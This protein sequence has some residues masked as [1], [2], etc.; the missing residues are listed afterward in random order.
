MISEKCLQNYAQLAIQLGVNV[1]PDQ[2]LVIIAPVDCADF[3]RRCVEEGYKAGAKEVR[4]QWSDERISKISYQYSSLQVLQ[5]IPDW[6]IEREQE[7]VDRGYCVLYLDSSI[8]SLMKDINQDL[9]RQVTMA[10]QTILEPFQNYTMAN[11]GQWSIVAVPN[12]QWAKKVFPQLSE[13]AAM[14]ALWD[15][16]LKTVRVSEE[17][18]ALQK[19]QAHNETLANT[20]RYLNEHHFQSLHFKNALGTN[21]TI[22]LVED[23]IWE[24]GSEKTTKEVLFNPNMPTE[25]A[26]T[27]PH[28]LGVQGKVV[29]TKPLSY[30][31]KLIDH[32]WIE[33]KDGK[34]VAWDAQQHKEA[35]DDLIEFDEG[36]SYLG[37]VALISNDSPI[38][39]SGILFYDTLFDE[40]ASCHLAL[41]RAYP[42]NIKDGLSMSEQQLI[43]KGYNFSKTHVD[44]MF[45]SDDMEIMGIQK[46]GKEVQLFSQGNFCVELK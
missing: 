19:W 20:C 44:F 42:S 21:L 7:Q 18:D 35:L 8:P 22:Q 36:S 5:H 34:A 32:F 28:R 43:E 13:D 10:R 29:A 25:E 12:V 6:F 17:G 24:G 16:I 38:S 31:G 27:M 41:G 45:G 11:Q 40:N 26:F 15:A 37:E 4:V 30:Q 46:D 23:H 2:L 14:Q 1:Q 9:I 39:Q 33:F 3:A